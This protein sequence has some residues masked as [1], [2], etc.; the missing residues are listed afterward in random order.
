MS[1]LIK[2]AKVFAIGHSRRIGADRSPA[3]QNVAS[4]LKSV[5][6]IVASVSHDEET[7]AAAWL[8]DVV[9]DTGVTICD[10]E[11]SFGTEVAKIVGELTLAN[12]TERDSIAKSHFANASAAAKTVKLADLID[13]C[14]D[15][16]K[17]DPAALIAC[18][19]E[20]NE[21]APALEGSDTRLLM[22]L[23]N[24]LKRYA[25]LPMLSTAEAP[26]FKPL[27][28]PVAALRVV[29]RALSARHIAQPLISFD[30]KSEAREVLEAM[31]LAGVEV[32]GL[33]TKGILWG[34]VE[35]S[36]LSERS[37]EACGREFAP[38][39]VVARRSSLAEVI[40]V[41]TRHDRCFVSA[42]KNV[43]GVVSRSDLHKPAVRM[44]LFGILTVAELEFT[45][46]IRKKWPK[47]AWV[48][49]ISR[50][51]IERATRLQAERERR[52]EKRQLLDCLQLSDKIEILISDPSEL[53]A[54]GIPSATAAR[55]VSSEIESLRNS[56][57]HAQDFVEQNW[58]QVVRLARRIHQIADEL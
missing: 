40:E 18:T 8:H 50:Q 31:T 33:H 21:L 52:K 39:Q 12:P 3:L 4:H 28:V 25:S 49:L 20:A 32:A 48:G 11:R 14:R 29:E 58:P 10:V 42:I 57:A 9:G 5:A 44:W 47:D 22:R 38:S 54:L 34:F 15:L 19:A 1:E 23:K 24:D 43:V 2:S 16:Y 46:R 6:Q 36:C 56:L 26:R 17:G 55:R 37:C 51:R 53:S 7:I 13:T 45:E 35:A 30:S 41:L 27:A